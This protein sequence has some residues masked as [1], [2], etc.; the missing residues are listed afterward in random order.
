MP[1]IHGCGDAAKQHAR[2]QHKA[3]FMA[4]NERKSKK[5]D[6]SYLQKKMDEKLKTMKNSR[7][8]GSASKH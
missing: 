6:K 2:K 1:E 8:G 5:V 3:N 7:S 4:D